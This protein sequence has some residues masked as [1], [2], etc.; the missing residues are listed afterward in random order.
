[1]TDDSSAAPTIHKVRMHLSVR[2]IIKV[3]GSLEKKKGRNNQSVAEELVM[4]MMLVSSQS[5]THRS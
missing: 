2:E 3:S 4:M 5:T 1:M